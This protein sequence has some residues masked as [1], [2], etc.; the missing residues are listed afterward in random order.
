[1]PTYADFEVQLKGTKKKRSRRF[2]LS[3]ESSFQDLARAIDAA[4]GWS[5]DRGGFF[6]GS[7]LGAA[8]IDIAS[9]LLDVFDPPITRG[10]VYVYDPEDAWW[11]HQVRLR[12]LKDLP[13][14]FDR[15]LLSAKRPFPDEDQGN[16]IAFERRL[17]ENAGKEDDL[18]IASLKESFDG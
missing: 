17:A 2:L 14:S 6:R 11:E 5:G 1:M 18:D 16:L 9:P 12:A 7:A 13:Q 4:C 10:C 8:D 3:A 15:R